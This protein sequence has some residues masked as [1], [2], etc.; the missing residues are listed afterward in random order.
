[1]KRNH[2]IDFFRFIFAMLI[3]FYHYLFHILGRKTGWY[4]GVEFYFILSGFFLMK[5]YEENKK[6]CLGEYKATNYLV[7]KIK[8]LYPHYLFSFL[9]MF[10]V[11]GI[12]HHK[13]FLLLVEE[14]SNIFGKYLCCKCLLLGWGY[15]TG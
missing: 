11:M 9:V 6:F 4:I 12:F 15:S 7:D 13:S 2:S 10:F 1:M 5:S 3:V 8:K 14:G